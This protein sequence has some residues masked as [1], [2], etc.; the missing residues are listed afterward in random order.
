MIEQAYFLGL[1]QSEL[2]ERHRLPL[3]TVKTR[4]RTGLQALRRQLDARLAA[5]MSERDE[6]LELDEPILLALAES[7]RGPA[8][9]PEVKQQA[10][11]AAV[12]RRAAAG[13]SVRLAAADDWLPHPVPG[14]RM[15]VLS[16]NRRS[17]YA[18]LLLD[19]APARAFPR[20]ITTATRSVTSC[21]AR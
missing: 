4:M 9:R 10:A 17:G 11:G 2:A 3:G 18:T 15:K 13:F 19:V 5:V 8:P 7:V 21:R 16:V 1:T 12:R 14:I 6:T 20:T